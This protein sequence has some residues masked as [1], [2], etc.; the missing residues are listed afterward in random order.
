MS[1]ISV[2]EKEF[3]FEEKNRRF[4]FYLSAFHNE[5]IK[6]IEIATQVGLQLI[7]SEQM[8][9]AMIRFLKRGG[10]LSILINSEEKRWEI[11]DHMKSEDRYYIKTEQCIAYWKRL[12]MKFPDS[13]T[14][15]VTE[16][17][18]LHSIFFT[19]TEEKMDSAIYVVYYTYTV[20]NV[21]SVPQL[22]VHSGEEYFDIYFSELR[23]LQDHAEEII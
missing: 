15:F 6:K 16:I 4:C 9:T 21:E 20:Y 12:K 8:N 2:C 1:P 5:N 3:S 11:G 10:K 7:N 14:I 17:P 19:A 18:L 23:Y 22:L 13:L